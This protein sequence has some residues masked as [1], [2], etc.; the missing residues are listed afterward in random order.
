MEQN[1]EKGHEDAAFLNKYKKEGQVFIH[2]I[3]SLQEILD[4]T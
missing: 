3:P 2:T 1:K 4:A